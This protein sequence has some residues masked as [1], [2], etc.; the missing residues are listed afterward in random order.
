MRLFLTGLGSLWSFWIGWE[1]TWDIDG[2]STSSRSPDLLAPK[3]QLQKDAAVG[4]D[5]AAAR[6]Q[7]LDLMWYLVWMEW[8]P[9]LERK[10]TSNNLTPRVV[11][12]NLGPLPT[13]LSCWKVRSR[14]PGKLSPGLC[15][16]ICQGTTSHGGIGLGGGGGWTPTPTW[17]GPAATGGDRHGRHH[18]VVPELRAVR[19]GVDR[20]VRGGEAGRRGG[21]PNTAGFLSGVGDVPFG[22]GARFSPDNSP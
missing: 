9:V 19:G 14:A 6:E 5:V 7:V 3:I 16:L 4:V 20:S 12:C 8:M 1:T 22:C 11:V 21:G 17:I 15:Q 18:R 13:D 10:G 2:V